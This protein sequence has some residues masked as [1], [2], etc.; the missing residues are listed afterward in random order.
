[1]GPITKKAEGDSDGEIR[2]FKSWIRILPRERI[3]S[4]KCTKNATGLRVRSRCLRGREEYEKTKRRKTPGRE[5]I[6]ESCGE[7]AVPSFEE[8]RILRDREAGDRLL[9]RKSAFLL[10]WMEAIST[11]R[12]AELKGSPKGLMRKDEFVEGTDSTEETIL[13]REITKSKKEEPV[14]GL[15]EEIIKKRRSD[16]PA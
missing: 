13:S 11:R 2:L 8:K 4:S 3:E 15:R 6:C 10:P 9:R 14:R 5:R 1:M 7:E 12:R 16:G